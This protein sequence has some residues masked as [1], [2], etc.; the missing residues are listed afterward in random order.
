MDKQDNRKKDR[1]LE[2]AIRTCNKGMNNVKLEE[3]STSALNHV[4][5]NCKY[6]M[7]SAT[8]TYH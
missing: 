5:M 7:A 8:D 3:F 1:Q 6:I 4:Y 2:W